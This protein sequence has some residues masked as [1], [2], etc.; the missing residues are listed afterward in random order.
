MKKDDVTDNEADDARTTE[1]ELKF[2]GVDHEALRARLRE[3]E[4]EPQG[5]PALE[6]NLLFDRDGELEGA[7]KLLRLRSD[8]RGARL[9][10]KGPPSY[11]G[12]LKVRRELET[13][14]GDLDT[15]RALLEALGY[16]RVQR[17]QKYREEWLLGS[18]VIALDHTPIGDFA[19]FEGVDCERVARRCGF[20]AEDAERR[21]YLRLY[22]DYREEH[23]EADPE[24]IFPRDKS[25]GEMSSE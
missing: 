25:P 6:D 22:R 5:P 8:R 14:V 17:Y 16:E 13:T 9:A 15:T 18:I 23:P 21:N 20:E 24:M 7:E 11:E 3:L 1:R 10:F 2:A 12:H 19:E 4:A